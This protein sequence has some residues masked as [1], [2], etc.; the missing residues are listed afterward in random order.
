MNHLS[1]TEHL[2]GKY[3]GTISTDF[4]QVADRLKD[5]A[6]IIRE[7]GNYSYP[8]FIVA[9]NPINLGALL[10]DK[11]EMNNE[12]YYYAAYLEALIE[13]QVIDPEK[14]ADFKAVYKDPDEFCCLL[15]ID[16]ANGF[17]NFIYMP[18]PV[19]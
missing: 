15:V 13:A 1:K 12:W 5:V 7:R 9:N 16:Q 3:L 17:H 10:I 8:V 18:Y 4:I 2:D 6:Y 14:A 11:G 19:D